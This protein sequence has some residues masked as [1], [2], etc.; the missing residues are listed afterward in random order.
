[1]AMRTE[2]KK[3]KP[4]RESDKV[5]IGVLVS[6]ETHSCGKEQVIQNK[7]VSKITYEERR[8]HFRW[9]VQE[10]PVEGN[11]EERPV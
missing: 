2:K 5:G 9:D 4:E 8:G 6:Y 7:Q 10:S 3:V 1:M 11:F